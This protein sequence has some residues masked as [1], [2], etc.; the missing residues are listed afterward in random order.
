MKDKIYFEYLPRIGRLF[1][2]LKCYRSKSEPEKAITP[3]LV[4]VSTNHIAFKGLQQP[5]FCLIIGW[6]DFCLSF[7][8]VSAQW[9]YG[10][11]KN[12]E[13]RKHI[14]KGNV[15]FIIFNKG[16]QAYVDGVGHTEDK[17]VDFDKSW[18]PQFVPDNETLKI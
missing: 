10:T 4:F 8:V 15:Q 2:R 9:I 6:W 16:E 7:G 17:W 13:A 12:S 18:W 3:T 5:G 14:T 11:C 1:I